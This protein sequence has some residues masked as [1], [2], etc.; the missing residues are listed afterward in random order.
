MG[1]ILFVSGAPPDGLA[2]GVKV[3][4]RHAE[5]LAGM[6]FDAW[7]VAPLGRPVWFRSRAPLLDGNRLRVG[8]EDVLVFGEEMD[9][10]FTAALALPGRRELYCQNHHYLLHDRL[11]E[12]GLAE[13]GFHG[14]YAASRT[15][16][17]FLEGVMRWPGADVVVPPIDPA[18]FR[19]GAKTLR[20]ACLPRKLPEQAAF[21]RAVFRRMNPDLA[22][23]EWVEIAGRHEEEVAEILAGSAVFLSLARREG[24]GMAALEAMAAGCAVVGFHGMGGLDYATAE[25]GRWFMSDEALSCAAALA[26]TVRGLERGDPAVSAMVEAGRVTAAHYAPGRVEAQLRAHFGARG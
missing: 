23:I 9:R 16:E 14:V 8:A 24:L 26:E 13:A 15:I 11:G 5:L 7:V 10:V 6:G 19:P 25:N 17:G 1:R 2:G 22:G 21:I 18:L 12:R 3:V 4:H 20:I